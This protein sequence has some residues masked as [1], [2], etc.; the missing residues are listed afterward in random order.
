MV[1]EQFLDD[2][3]KALVSLDGYLHDLKGRASEWSDLGEGF[4]RGYLTTDQEQQ[5][6][7]L[8][9]SYSATRNALFDIVTEARQRVRRPSA[10]RPG[11]F[12]VPFAAALTLVDAARF[13]RF[14]ANRRPVLRRKLNE[15]VPEFNIAGGT[16]DR[17]Q[18][19]LFSWSH[20]W[21]LRQA[22][23][24]F[25]RHR[26]AWRAMSDGA[27]WWP[28]LKIA[29]RHRHALDVS[30]QEF[31]DASWRTGSDQWLR[32]LGRLALA[33]PMFRL[34]K[35][36]SSM[37]AD[38]YVKPRHRPA[39]PRKVSSQLHD[40]L[41]PGDVLLVR[42]EFALT[43]YFLPGYWPHAALFLGRRTDL[44]QL[45]LQQVDHLRGAWSRLCELA[46]S[47]GSAVLEAMKDG[48]RFRAISSPFASNSCLV[49]RPRLQ[50]QEVREA[51]VRVTRHEGK[52][53]DFD[54]NFSKADGLVCTEVVYRAYDGV[55]GQELPLQY[56]AGRPTLS[57]A[58]LLEIALSDRCFELVAAYIPAVERRRVHTAEAARHAVQKVLASR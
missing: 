50:P 1:D 6:V 52:P 49:L 20:G 15:P 43:N 29:E 22:A 12:L 8:L 41:K 44:D 35:I 31:L 57:G 26:E 4:A 21:H 18:A 40:L 42:K 10:K 25:D 37:M 34:Q 54:F 13:V 38:V 5:V 39:M 30:V 48:V 23:R 56:R 7:S 55:A 47:H 45:E 33:R 24:F 58:D 28:A 27:D 36:T 51:I 16:Y 19:S 2:S 3:V 17:I 46:E 32:A 53:Y 14:L 11:E 9:V